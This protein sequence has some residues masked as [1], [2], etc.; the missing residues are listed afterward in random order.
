MRAGGADM[1]RKSKS[2][3]KGKNMGKKF[4]ALEGRVTIRTR[5]GQKVGC[6]RTDVRRG[7]G[8][9]VRAVSDP[10]LGGSGTCSGQR[11]GC[12]KLAVTVYRTGG[13]EKL[14]KGTCLLAEGEH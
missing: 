10:P 9:H 6:M 2:L 12:G 8:R 1:T 7:D 14:G 3:E 13:V 5:V 11:G 4:R